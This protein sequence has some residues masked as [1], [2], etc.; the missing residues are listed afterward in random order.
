MGIKSLFKSKYLLLNELT[1]TQNKLQ[2]MGIKNIAIDISCWI[3]KAKYANNCELAINESSKAW[4]Y[5]IYHSFKSL[6][7]N[8]NLIFVFDGKTPDHKLKEHF[9]RREN[10]E[11]LIKLGKELIK[12]KETEL[13]GKEL[14][15]KT[16]ETVTLVSKLIDF[17]EQIK[18]GKYL[19]AEYEA[20][21]LLAKLSLTKEVDLIITEDTDLIVYG[22]EKILFKYKN[23]KGMLYLKKESIKNNFFLE[24]WDLF[25][26]FCIL[27]GCDYA[28]ISGIALK[29]A[30]NI[31]ETREKYNEW[32][33]NIEYND[34]IMIEDTVKLFTVLIN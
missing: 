22:C 17:I 28:K 32:E 5:M 29:K 21:S 6:S 20:D 18:L 31:C 14:L 25:K 34:K 33:K 11:N 10:N 15:V 2:E 19:Q 24:D 4:L 27:C 30:E 1:S 9:K 23:D 7:K 3:H 13:K 12:N 16:I 26:I 8:F